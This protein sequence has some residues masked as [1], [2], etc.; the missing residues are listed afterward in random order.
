MDI[1]GLFWIFLSVFSLPFGYRPIIF[2][3]IISCIFQASVFLTIGSS[4]IPLYLGIEVIALI[5]LILPYKG[6]GLLKFNDY[7][8][9]LFVF[10][11]IITW[12]LSY[13]LAN[14]FDG[15]FVYNGQNSF[16][17]SYRLG[18]IPLHW[19]GSNINQLV[20]LSIHLLF[21]L[22][23]YKRRFFI[24]KE[25]CFKSIICAILIFLLVSLVWKFLPNIYNMLALF[26][27][28]NNIKDIPSALVETRL[29]STFS[30]P[31]YA[32]VFIAT[33]LSPLLFNKDS[34]FKVLGILLAYLGLLNLSTSFIFSLLVS[35][36]IVLFFSKID[37][38]KK[39]LYIA[40]IL[41]FCTII[42]FTFF[43][44]IESYL[45]TKSNSTSGVVRSDGNRNAIENFI[46]SYFLGIGV[47]SERASSLLVNILNNL[48]ILIST[49]ILFVLSRV[50]Y[51]EEGNI[52]KML[53]ISLF[54]AFF[55]CFSA[56]PEYTWSLLWVLIF[57]N[58]C[59]SEKV[60][61]V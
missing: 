35:F 32:G 44:L 4:T 48:G 47:G 25:F 29:S 58:I 59:L 43:D 30:E 39:L 23:I 52:P 27:Y 38:D 16:E 15:I 61:R 57:S 22:V 34:K 50:I 6:T 11:I 1:F 19:S 36:V 10:T 3:L 40:L 28:N 14:T 49:L 2:I 5:R 60:N 17:D 53:K 46:S 9:G 56:I 20:L 37:R 33:F 7:L 42:Y 31:S 54:I 41:F 45:S 24:S 21:T 26:M 18:G 8:S 51:F 13:L 12:V 55:G